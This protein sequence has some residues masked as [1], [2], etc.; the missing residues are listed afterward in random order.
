MTY[1][2]FL[3]QPLLQHKLSQNGPGLAIGDINKDGLEDIF[4][5]GSYRT[6][7]YVMI[8]NSKGNFTMKAFTDDYESEDQ[9]SL[10]FDVDN[11]GDQDLYVVSGGVEFFEGHQYYQDRLYRNDGKGNLNKRYRGIAPYDSKADRVSSREIMI[12]METLIFLLVAGAFLGNIQLASK[13]YLL[14]NDH[15]KFTDV[16]MRFAPGLYSLGW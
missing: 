11:D 8:Q 3:Y 7:A 15:G 9:G 6:Q 13:S 1:N 5:G 2:D 12:R 14:R 16:T 4:I 10:F